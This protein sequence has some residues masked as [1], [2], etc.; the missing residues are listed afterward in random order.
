MTIICI[1]HRA[2]LSP[3]KRSWYQLTKHN[4][5]CEKIK[6]VLFN[7][8]NKI[9]YLSISPKNYVYHVEMIKTTKKLVNISAKYLL[10][11]IRMQVVQTGVAEALKL[12]VGIGK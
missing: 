5:C 6:F 1:P 3:T 8:F 12:D 11:E 10:L 7:P 2:T 4:G 9:K